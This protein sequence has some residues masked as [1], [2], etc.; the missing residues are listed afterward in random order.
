[1]KKIIMAAVLVMGLAGLAT[2]QTQPVTSGKKT[3][4]QAHKPGTSKSK[5][6]HHHGKKHHRHAKKTAM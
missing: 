3:E 6:T 4:K 1:M 2:A 5:G